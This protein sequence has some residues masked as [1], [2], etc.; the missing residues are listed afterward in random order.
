MS[1][2]LFLAR[3]RIRVLGLLSTLFSATLARCAHKHRP[4][5]YPTYPNTAVSETPALASLRAII[6]ITRR[7]LR[8]TRR[9]RFMA[10]HD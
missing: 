3:R 6:R 2:I 10:F 9:W 5:P 8:E 1:V 7:G 4:I